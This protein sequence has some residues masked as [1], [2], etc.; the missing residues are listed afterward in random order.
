[1]RLALNLELFVKTG[2]DLS[3]GYE[4]VS[5][6]KVWIFVWIQSQGSS[7]DISCGLGEIVLCLLNHQLLL[8]FT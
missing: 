8:Y 1:M 2:N 5:W 4:A 7:L 3:I 6:I